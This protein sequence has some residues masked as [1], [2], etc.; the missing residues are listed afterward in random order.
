VLIAPEYAS[1]LAASEWLDDASEKTASTP[2]NR[3]G[4]FYR[5]PP[6][7]R[8]VNRSQVAETASGCSV[9]SYETVSGH[10]VARYY[11]PTSGRFLSVD[12]L[13]HAASRSL[14]DFCNG[15]PVNSFDP[16]GREV[17]LTYN[18]D[19]SVTSPVA[20]GQP[21]LM[22]SLS[23]RAKE[24]VTGVLTTTGGIV[25]TGVGIVTAESGVGVPIILA[26]VITFDLGITQIAHG[27]SGEGPVQT[28]TGT[29]PGGPIELTGAMTG[30]PNLQ[31]FGSLADPLFPLPTDGW[32]ALN[33]TS[34]LL[35]PPE[36]SPDA[37]PFAPPAQPSIPLPPV[38]PQNN[39]P[40]TPPKSCP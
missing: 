32:A 33:A 7:R 34:I 39:K 23:P 9:R 18:S 26:G 1:S 29:V 13:G 22:D 16:D 15:D 28:P 37:W 17:G 24:V 11:E 2:K 36:F 12:P 14:Y 4:V 6:V 5:K 10:T 20:T 27:L 8:R 31:T 30:N 35:N 25:T 21:T 40:S 19:G 38:D 3:V